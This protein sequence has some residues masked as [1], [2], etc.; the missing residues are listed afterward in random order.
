MAYVFVI[1]LQKDDLSLA[2]SNDL[3][4]AGLT[5]KGGIFEHIPPAHIFYS[6]YGKYDTILQHSYGSGTGEI[7]VDDPHCMALC[8]NVPV[9]ALSSSSWKGRLMVRVCNQ[10]RQQHVSLS[11]HVMCADF[12]P[13]QQKL[14][15]RRRSERFLCGHADVF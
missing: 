1:H 10:S 2:M 13:A 8:H 9:V 12:Q 3:V 7:K 14:L 6:S 11:D 5:A 4:M 15:R